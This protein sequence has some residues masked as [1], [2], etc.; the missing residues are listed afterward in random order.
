MYLSRLS[1]NLRNRDV[2]KDLAHP[3]EMHRTIMKAFPTTLQ[4]GEERVLYRLEPTMH[5]SPPTLLVQSK[6]L[7]MWANLPSD[8]LLDI[9]DQHTTQVKP[10]T[11][12]FAPGQQF[13]FRLFANPTKRHNNKRHSTKT[14]STNDTPLNTLGKRVGLYTPDAQIE[15]LHRKG[16]AHGFQIITVIPNRQTEIQDQ[17]FTLTLLGVQFEG[18]LQASDPTRLRQSIINGIGSGK[19]FGCGLLSLAPTQ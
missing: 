16:Q 18:L 2:K 5:N 3:Y 8:Y 12:D 10:I 9:P 1:L 14:H 6:L 19:A 15:W 7:P 11:L 13:V 17:K 4:A